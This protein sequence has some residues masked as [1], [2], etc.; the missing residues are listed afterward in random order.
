M[1]LLQTG[2]I[3]NVSVDAEQADILLRLLDA[4]VIKLEGGTE[5]DLQVLDMKPSNAITSKDTGN[6]EKAE[7]KN[8]SATEQQTE[9]KYE[10]I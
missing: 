3:D 2:D 10:F 7:I 5:E 1:D 9:K 4:V 8:K 6:K